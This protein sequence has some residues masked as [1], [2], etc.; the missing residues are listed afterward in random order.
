VRQPLRQG[1]TCKSRKVKPSRGQAPG[2]R[3]ST[4]ALAKVHDS[5]R[6]TSEARG[7]STLRSKARGKPTGSGESRTRGSLEGPP[8]NQRI[9]RGGTREQGPTRPSARRGRTRSQGTTRRK[10]EEPQ[11]GSGSTR[12]ASSGSEREGPT[13]RGLAEHLGA[14]PLHLA[15]QGGPE[16]PRARPRAE[17]GLP[18]RPKTSGTPAGHARARAARDRR[19]TR[20]NNKQSKREDPGPSGRPQASGN[21]AGSCASTVGLPHVECVSLQPQAGLHA[22]CGR[23]GGAGGETGATGEKPRRQASG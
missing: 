17:G 15:P 16:G 1:T 8:S 20:R 11:E 22:A 21:H 10:A 4:G 12:H 23:L 19:K 5:R 2:G 14:H 6:G 3:K 13:R 7:T 18:Q 9:E